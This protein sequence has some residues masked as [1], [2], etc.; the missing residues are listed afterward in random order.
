MQM[1]QSMLDNYNAA[2]R[3]QERKDSCYSSS[4]Q[5]NCKSISNS[6]D[7]RPGDCWRSLKRYEELRYLPWEQGS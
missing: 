4:I 5:D 2:K 3:K 1:S 6:G 7:K